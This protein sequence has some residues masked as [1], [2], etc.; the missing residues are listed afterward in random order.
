MKQIHPEGPFFLKTAGI[1]GFGQKQKYADF[2]SK[3]AYPFGGGC[4]IRTRV[5]LPSN[6]FQDRPVMTA[7]VTLRIYS[8]TVGFQDRP[9]MPCCGA[10][11]LPLAVRSQDFDRC[12]SF[13]LASSAPGGARKRPRL[14]MDYTRNALRLQAQKRRAGEERKARRLKREAAWLVCC[15]RVLLKSRRA[16]PAAA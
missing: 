5:R 3:S 11:N 6:G 2:L 12:H 8:F 13:L 16:W 15:I 7:S 4:R 14:R 10:R 1:R 9:V